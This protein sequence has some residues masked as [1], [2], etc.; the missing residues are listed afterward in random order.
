MS[1]TLGVIGGSG[2]Y[3]LDGLT[4]REEIS[5]DTP[6]GPPSDIITAGRLGDTR[7]LFLPRHGRGHRLAP[8]EIEYR[9]NIFALKAAGAEQVLSVSAVGS[10][11][12]EYRPGELVCVDQYIDETRARPRS[13][14]ER[15]GMVAHV[16]FADPTC[17]ALREALV[18]SAEEVGAKVHPR[19]TYVCIEGPQ[20]STRFESKAFRAAGA[21]IIG[22]T[23]LPEARLAREA[24]LPYASLA[25]VTD[26]D[27]W[28]EGEAVDMERV[29]AVMRANVETARKVVRALAKRLPDPKQSPASSAMATAI[30]TARDRIPAETLKSL[31]PL[32]GKYLPA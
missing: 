12:E 22:M 32:L 6:W 7:L 4:D 5:H 2:L 21:D 11:R 14:F 20:F 10:L 9:A 23:N 31:A 17:D 13:F 16:A 26:Y 15:R 27:A 1:R 25:L 30:A 19:G 28:K 18:A 8:H 24:E 3:E 29:V